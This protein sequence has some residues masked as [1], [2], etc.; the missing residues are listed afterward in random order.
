MTTPDNPAFDRDKCAKFALNY[1]AV[2]AMPVE[3]VEKARLLRNVLFQFN[4][5][6]AVTFAALGYSL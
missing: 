1:V 3:Q 6:Y 4:P 2:A 5:Q